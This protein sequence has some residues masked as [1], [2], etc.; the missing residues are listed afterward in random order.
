MDLDLDKL[1]NSIRR[2]VEEEDLV[3]YL[4]DL[5]QDEDIEDIDD[6]ANEDSQIRSLLIGCLV[7]L[8][9]DEGIAD[10]KVDKI[11]FNYTHTQT[12]T[13]DIEYLNNNQCELCERFTRL[14]IHHLL[15]KSEHKRLI[16]RG[17]FDKH[18]CDNLTIKICRNCHN[19]CHQYISNKDLADEFN[20]IDKLLSNELIYKFVKFN[21]RQ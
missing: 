7:E 20:S 9:V 6:I 17:L 11:I 2:E 5:I 15:P 13:Q 8:G 3:E 12:H 16:K 10:E 14:T 19:S 21:S 1:G 4:I 18:Q